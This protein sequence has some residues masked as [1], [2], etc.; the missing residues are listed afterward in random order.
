MK[1]MQEPKK[2]NTRKRFHAFKHY[3]PP[4]ISGANFKYVPLTILLGTRS[5][6]KHLN[7]ADML[8]VKK[9]QSLQNIPQLSFNGCAK[10]HTFLSRSIQYPFSGSIV[11]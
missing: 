11:M 8:Q 9:F 1:T 2:M 5:Y 3:L 10:I 6:V 7:L 4:I